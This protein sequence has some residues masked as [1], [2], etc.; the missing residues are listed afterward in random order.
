MVDRDY[1]LRQRRIKTLCSDSVF[2]PILDCFNQFIF[3]FQCQH[4]SLLGLFFL[5]CDR[6]VEALGTGTVTLSSAALSRLAIGQYI[7]L[8]SMKSAKFNRDIKAQNTARY[9]RTCWNF[10]NRTPFDCSTGYHVNFHRK[11]KV[12]RYSS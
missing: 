9:C 8:L 6:D 3:L 10:W 4:P 12:S 5:D 1:R 11:L 7:K 2:L